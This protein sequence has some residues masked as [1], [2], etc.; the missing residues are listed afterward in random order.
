MR[1]PRE[2]ELLVLLIVL[3]LLVCWLL[4]LSRTG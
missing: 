3:T 1:G 2:E 4:Y